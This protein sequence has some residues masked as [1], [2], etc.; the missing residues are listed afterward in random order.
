M[1]KDRIAVRLIYVDATQGWIT[2][3]DANAGTQAIGQNAS[4][5]YLVV[6]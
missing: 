5:E 2:T 6:G 3:V 1:S 4:V